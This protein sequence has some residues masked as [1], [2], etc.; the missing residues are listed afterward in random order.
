MEWGAIAFSDTHTHTHI[1]ILNSSF[2]IIEINDLDSD[3]KNL[4][5][6]GRQTIHQ[7]LQHSLKH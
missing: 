2:K 4:S 1:H 7:L 5:L 6:V 3:L